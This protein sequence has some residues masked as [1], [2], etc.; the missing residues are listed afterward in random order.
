MSACCEMTQTPLV[1][2][3]FHIVSVPPTLL[4]GYS[5]LIQ[6]ERET[7]VENSLLSTM[8]HTSSLLCLWHSCVVVSMISHHDLDHLTIFHPSDARASATTATAAAP[9]RLPRRAR[10][11]DAAASPNGA[12]I[13]FLAKFHP[14]SAPHVPLTRVHMCAL[15]RAEAESDPQQQQQMRRAE[16]NGSTSAEEGGDGSDDADA[17]YSLDLLQAFPAVCQKAKS[18]VQTCHA[19]AA[20][21]QERAA[22]EAA[23]A[24]ALQRVA[25]CVSSRWC[26]VMSSGERERVMSVCAAAHTQVGE[27]GRLGSAAHALVAGRAADAG[28]GSGGARSGRRQDAAVDGSGGEGVRVA[29]GAPGAASDSRF[30]AVHKSCVV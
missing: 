27:G 7:R 15:V 17:R 29:A 8:F 19:V 12:T 28:D 26:Y 22:M 10:V 14:T 24:K 21:V 25:Q 5:S 9:M 13:K 11:P 3:S 4:A 1:N 30:G 2:S 6:R 20:F 18:G 23:Y 16:S